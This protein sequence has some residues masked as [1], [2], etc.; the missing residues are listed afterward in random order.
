MKKLHLCLL[1]VL[2]QFLPTFSSKDLSKSPP[3]AVSLISAI[4]LPSP[5]F[6]HMLLLCTDPW[7]TPPP[8]HHCL[9][10]LMLGTTYQGHFLETSKAFSQLPCF[11]SSS[12]PELL[13]PVLNFGLGISKNVHRLNYSYMY[14]ERKSEKE[15]PYYCLPQHS[16]FLW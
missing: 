10:L 6:P 8:P 13:S 7:H 14:Q 1:P 9:M 12:R 16:Y 3:I 15:T 5:V 2:F 11:A 4:M